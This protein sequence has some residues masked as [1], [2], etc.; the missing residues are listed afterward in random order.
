MLTKLYSSL[1][2]PTKDITSAETNIEG[3]IEGLNVGVILARVDDAER[4]EHP[5]NSEQNKHC[6]GSTQSTPV[7]VGR[8]LLVL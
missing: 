8:L 6:N 2:Q 1:T 7:F 5:G 3:C 4:A